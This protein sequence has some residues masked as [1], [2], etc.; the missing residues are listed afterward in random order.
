[1]TAIKTETVVPSNLKKI[2]TN[3]II[4]YGKQYIKLNYYKFAFVFE[5]F[6]SDAESQ[7]IQQ[8]QQKVDENAKTYV[9]WCNCFLISNPDNRLPI[10][11][12]WI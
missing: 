11:F 8:T 12:R 3:K 5:L 1:M 2:E 10:H 9:A 4:S 7:P 6:I